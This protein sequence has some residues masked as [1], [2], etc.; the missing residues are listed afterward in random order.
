MY[1]KRAKLF[2]LVQWSPAFVVDNVSGSVIV[3]QQVDAFQYVGGVLGHDAV[4]ERRQSVSVLVVGRRAK[5]QQ[6]LHGQAK[7]SE[8]KSKQ[9]TTQRFEWNPSSEFTIKTKGL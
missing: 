2:Y 6:C 5:L 8:T 4:V 3:E 9:F 7:M 1:R